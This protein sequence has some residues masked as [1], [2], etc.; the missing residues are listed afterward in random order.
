[1]SKAIRVLYTCVFVFVNVRVYEV[2]GHAKL[3]DCD[4]ECDSKSLL[5]AQTCF[6]AAIWSGGLQA[7]L[8]LP[9]MCE[10]SIY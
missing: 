10:A 1:M 3:G 4:P 9:S 7:E 6:S 8:M 2:R 5:A